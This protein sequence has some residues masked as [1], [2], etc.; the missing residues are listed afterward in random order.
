MELQ[1]Q[2]MRAQAELKAALAL[3]KAKAEHD[4]TFKARQVHFTLE[5]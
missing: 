4:A 1:A 3:E 2:L 5:T